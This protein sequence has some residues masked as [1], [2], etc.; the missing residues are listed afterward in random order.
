MTVYNYVHF[1]SMHENEYVDIYVYIFMNVFVCW[2]A[3]MQL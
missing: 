2:L 1:I 3:C